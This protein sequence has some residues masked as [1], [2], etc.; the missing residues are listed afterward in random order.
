MALPTHPQAL[1]CEGSPPGQQLCVLATAT[2]RRL[3]TALQVLLVA[4]GLARCY[5]LPRLVE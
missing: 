4:L 3:S 2:L 1:W 5:T